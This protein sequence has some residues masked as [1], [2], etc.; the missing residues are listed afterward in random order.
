LEMPLFAAMVP[1][2]A[3]NP[4]ITIA[5]SIVRILQEIEGVLRDSGA[6][7]ALE[8]RAGTTGPEGSVRSGP[9]SIGDQLGEARLGVEGL[10]RHLLSAVS[11]RKRV[12]HDATPW[13][14][15]NKELLDDKL[16]QLGR[17]NDVL[18]SILPRELRESILT[19]GMSGLLLAQPEEAGSIAGLDRGAISQQAKLLQVHRKLAGNESKNSS[20]S[21]YSR[22][23]LLHIDRSDIQG[24]GE[25]FSIVCSSG[26][27]PGKTMATPH[28]IS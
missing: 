11:W 5:Q 21:D 20:M 15:S 16:Q 17:W 27:Q 26:E 25:S 28:L 22:T 8:S 13:R 23:R 24:D 14:Q 12:K 3:Q 7:S 10:S 19:Q 6:L 1:P 2:P 18:F 4:V 9:R